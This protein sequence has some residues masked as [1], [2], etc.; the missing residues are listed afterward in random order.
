VLLLWLGQH[1]VPPR[2]FL[3]V[4]AP[5]CFAGVCC[6]VASVALSSR[7]VSAALAGY[8]RCD[9]VCDGAVLGAAFVACV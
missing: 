8:S 5:L 3:G 9:G 2:P 4:G 6:Q 7:G 1:W